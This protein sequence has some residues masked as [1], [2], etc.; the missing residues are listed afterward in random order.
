VKYGRMNPKD[1]KSPEEMYKI[2]K[3]KGYKPGWAYHQ[4]IAKGWMKNAG[5]I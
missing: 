1:A 4:I 5:R 3:A 2:A